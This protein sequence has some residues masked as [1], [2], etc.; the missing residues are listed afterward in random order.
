MAAFGDNLGNTVVYGTGAGLSAYS[1]ASN[2]SVQAMAGRIW[3][4]DAGTFPIF[5]ENVPNAGPRYY[6][7]D[8][9]G[10]ESLAQ[11]LT[12][13]GYVPTQTAENFNVTKINSMVDAMANGTFD[14]NAS[15]LQ[16]VYL[17]PGKE[18]IGGHHRI[19]ASLLADVDLNQV[20]SQL[21][22]V[23]SLPQ[24]FRPEYRWTDVL[25]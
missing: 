25:P 9:A 22:Q 4:E 3:S 23:R 10:R 6:P 15:S 5:G 16:P 24:N 20:P 21:P 17:G 12:R 11:A 13:E 18:I 7:T 14:W 19:I 2:P 1:V 8:A